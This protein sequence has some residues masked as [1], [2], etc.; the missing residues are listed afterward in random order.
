MVSNVIIIPPFSKNKCKGD[1]IRAKSMARIFKTIGYDVEVLEAK[2]KYLNL[3]NKYKATLFIWKDLSKRIKDKKIDFVYC[4]GLIPFKL[5]KK[6]KKRNIKI[7]IDLPVEGPPLNWLKLG[8]FKGRLKT[9]LIFLIKAIQFEV[10]KK[11]IDYVLVENIYQKRLFLKYK[12]PDKKL[13]VT[14][15]SID[16]SKYK[17]SKLN[18]KTCIFIGS[19]KQIDKLGGFL[20][21]FKKVV[22][23][24]DAKFIVMGGG[25]YL[26][27]YKNFTKILKLNKNI[28]FLGSIN[29][30]KIP[31]MLEKASIA[32]STQ[33]PA[34]KIPEYMAA[35]LPIIEIKDNYLIKDAKS[36]Y[37]CKNWN[38]Y[39]NKLIKLL[40]NKNLREKF[41]KHGRDYI[42]KHRDYKIVAN[43]LKEKLKFR[44]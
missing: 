40:N 11:Y 16:L 29:P 38:D 20:K 22:E 37:I 42:E 12:F 43:E 34:T 19:L 15:H 18:N 41:G 23:E 7:I 27:L 44:H 39:A 3:K 35:G 21:I 9:K 5:V 10:I 17:V 25:E 13:I 31:K 14:P 8:K 26:P 2:E 32:I 33:G 24:T 1:M 4:R 36:G 30:E 28:K 6:L